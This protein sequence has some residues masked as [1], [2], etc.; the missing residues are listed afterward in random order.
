MKRIL[1]SLLILVAASTLKA[2]DTTKVKGKYE[3]AFVY[4]YAMYDSL[5]IYFEDGTKMNF[6]RIAPQPLVN[7]PTKGFDIYIKAFHFLE[8]K[9]YEL[10][11]SDANMVQ[12][13]SPFYIF[14]R[15]KE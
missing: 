3:Y 13:S 11:T 6:A 7:K 9:G 10:I 5:E 14:R 2:Q 4:L 1:L 8:D 15:R 12:N